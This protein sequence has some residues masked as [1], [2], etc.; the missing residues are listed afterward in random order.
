MRRKNKMTQ[1]ERYYSFSSYLKQTFGKKIY[2][3]SFDGGMT[4]PNRDGKIGRK[5]CV[6]CSEGGSGDF[7]VSLNCGIDLAI[8]TAKQKVAKK[9]T[10]NS[11]YIAYFQSYTNTYAS[12]DRLK[13]LFLPLIK[14]EEI[15][16]LS[17][18]TRPDCLPNEVVSLIGDLCKIKPVFVELGLQSIHEST[19]QFIR[20]GY[21]SKIFDDA[22]QKLNAVG[23]KVVVHLILGLP[24]ENEQM[25]LQSVKHISKLNIHGVKLQLL[26]VLQNTNLC[27]LYNN[28]I[29]ET[30]S[31]NEYIDLLAKCVELLPPDMVI[32]R[33]TGDAPKSILVAPKWSANKKMVLNSITKRFNELNVIQGKNFNKE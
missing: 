8:E 22:V 13:E 6:F 2:K 24:Y 12:V 20:R 10:E 19:A 9:T 4:C 3:L 27:D 5:G 25:I 32:H 26:H 14:R 7:A 1:P 18:G 17:I 16:A 33:L 23:A 15:V 21:E 31:L 30:L 28:G 29:F 11:G